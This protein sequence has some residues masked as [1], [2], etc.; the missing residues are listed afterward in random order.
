MQ[1]PSDLCGSLAHA[2]QAHPAPRLDLLQVEAL[3]FIPDLYPERLGQM[4]PHV[5]SRC[6]RVFHNVVQRLLGNAAQVLLLCGI[7]GLCAVDVGADI[8]RFIERGET[9][10][11]SGD[12]LGP[13]FEVFT[14]LPDPETPGTDRIPVPQFRLRAGRTFA[15]DECLDW[16]E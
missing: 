3:P 11:F 12:E 1:V 15:L 7:Q 5:R 14:V 2:G 8:R 6:L 4:Q 10:V 9:F 16:F 13:C